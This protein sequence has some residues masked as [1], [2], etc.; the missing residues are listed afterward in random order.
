MVSAAFKAKLEA[1]RAEELA[2]LKAI[3]TT[4]T[5]QFGHTDHTWE[6][7]AIIALAVTLIGGFFIACGCYCVSR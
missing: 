3:D 1:E 4:P 6:F 7:G 5:E 2:A